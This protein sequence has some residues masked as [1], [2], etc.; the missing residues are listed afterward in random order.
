MTGKIRVVFIG[1][2]VLGSEAARLLLK[3]EGFEIVG[4]CDMEKGIGQDLGEYLGEKETVGVNVTNDPDTIY[5]GTKA[6][7]AI[8]NIGSFIEPMAPIITNALKH[9]MNV[10]TAAEEVAYPFNEHPKEAE[11][12]DAVAKEHGVTVLATG[13]NPGFM[14]DALLISL[15]APC[16]DVTRVEA[17]RVVNVA[18]YNMYIL[19]HF[20]VGLTPEEFEESQ[21]RRKGVP[22]GKE[23][24]VCGHIGFPET[25][26]LV[27]KVLGWKL[28][29]KRQ[30]L[31]P[32]I[33]KKR[34]E[35]TYV[36]VDP[37][38]V[39][40]VRQVAHGIVKGESKIVFDF[41][42]QVLPEK[43][44][45]EIRIIGNPTINCSIQPGMISLIGTS[46]LEVNNIPHVLSARPGLLTPIDL[47]IPRALM[48]DVREAVKDL[49]GQI[50]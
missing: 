37:G 7:I 33:A 18:P 49:R 26:D 15:T 16:H 35:G 8:I 10:I 20:A 4:A 30:T 39:C 23:E 45:D 28:D 5:S 41:V 19:R 32:V 12:I 25:L 11:E 46:A 3:K 9:G 38:K 1:L 27:S 43:T 17:S 2:G 34:L 50:H 48:V 21:Q 36:T 42:A 13:L 47:P 44:A 22:V 31:E 14:Y 40:G 24:G 6:D 29:E